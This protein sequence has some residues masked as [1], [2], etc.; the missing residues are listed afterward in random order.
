MVTP[1]N[2]VIAPAGFTLRWAPG[3]LG[4]LQYFLPN[5]GEDQKKSYMSAEPLAMYHL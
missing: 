1:T 2:D 5:T 4:F 3:T